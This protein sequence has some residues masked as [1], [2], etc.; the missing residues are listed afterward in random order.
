V[1]DTSTPGRFTVVAQHGAGLDLSSPRVRGFID[2]LRQHHIVC[3]PTAADF[4]AKFLSR[5]GVMAPTYA[6]M[7]NRMSVSWQRSAKSGA[8]GLP[9]PPGMDARYRES[10]E[11]MVQMIGVLYRSGVTIV[12]GTDGLSFIWLPRE[13]ELYVNAGIPPAESCGSIPLPRPA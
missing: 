5:P 11:R 13:F 3:D 7:V 9:V 12:A 8:E 6:P 10:F 1:Q 2:L 4:E